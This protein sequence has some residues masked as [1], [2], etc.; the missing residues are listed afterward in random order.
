MDLQGAP[1]ISRTAPLT[2][3]IIIPSS[4]QRGILL[5]QQQLFREGYC[6]S[7]ERDTA[8]FV[9]RIKLSLKR[10]YRERY[11]YVT[12][13]KPLLEKRDTATPQRGIQLFH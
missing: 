13:L 2:V 5:G 1:N 6:Y 9:R 4:S 10:V 7:A 3:K 11:S 8:T 12:S